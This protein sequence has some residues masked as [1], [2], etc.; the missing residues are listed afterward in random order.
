MCR[1][2]RNWIHKN[3]YHSGSYFCNKTGN[4]ALH[5]ICVI[6]CQYKTKDCFLKAGPA[7]PCCDCH[8]SVMQITQMIM[9]FWITFPRAIPLCWLFSALLP[10][11]R[12]D[13]EQ[14][15]PADNLLCTTFAQEAPFP[16][17]VR[18]TCCMQ[19]GI[20]VLPM[21]LLSCFSS[22]LMQQMFSVPHVL[23]RSL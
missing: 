14:A 5:N 16:S 11:L 21:L 6:T 8:P 20:F 1:K 12:A 18:R 10:H 4:T 13:E 3:P 9:Q 23:F 2:M 19:C 17:V 22:S 15:G 7:A